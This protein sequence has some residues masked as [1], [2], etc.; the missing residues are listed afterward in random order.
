MEEQHQV[1]PESE[2]ALNASTAIEHMPQ[3]KDIV[4]EKE[5]ASGLLAKVYKGHQTLLQRTVAM[6]IL[7]KKDLGDDDSSLERFQQEASLAANLDHPNIAKVLGYG[8]ASSGDPYLTME[9][10]D[11]VTLREYLDSHSQQELSLKDFKAIFLPLLSALDYAHEKGIVHR[12]IK[13]G[14]IMLTKSVHD[15]LLPKLV[16]FGIAK[17]FIES[18]I[19]QHHTK[20]GTVIGTPAYMSPEQCLGK[21]VDGRSDLY[22]IACVMYEFLCSE[23]LFKAETPLALMGMHAQAQP[24][25]VKEFCRKSMQSSKLCST[26]LSTLQ[27]DP[28]ERPKTAA[29][30]SEKLSNDLG[31]LDSFNSKKQHSSVK[32]MLAAGL[33]ILLLASVVTALFNLNK[34]KAVTQVINEPTGRQL[35][36]LRIAKGDSRNVRKVLSQ[37]LSLIETLRKKED[38]STRELAEAYST[39]GELISLLLSQNKT[40]PKQRKDLEMQGLEL[41]Q[42]GVDIS[43]QGNMQ[44]FFFRNTRNEYELLKASKDGEKSIIKLIEEGNAR[45]PTSSE[46]IE[47][48]FDGILNSLTLNNTKQAKSFLKL[49]SNQHGEEAEHIRSIWLRAAEARIAIAENEKKKALAIIKPVLKELDS[50]IFMSQKSTIA[51]LQKAIGPILISANRAEQYTELLKKEVAL[52]GE[53]YSY[54]GIAQLYKMIAESYRVRNREEDAIDYTEKALHQYEINKGDSSIILDLCQ[55]LV[56]EISDMKDPKYSAKLAAYKAKVDSLTAMAGTK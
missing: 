32:N 5:L 1:K 26:I 10:V 46:N 44:K 41:A 18:N 25:S 34:S 2:D 7:S 21:P 45:W 4:L 51:L 40:S 50:G 35:S 55:R 6:K 39:A 28:A 17:V 23:A 52:R 37:Y 11:G 49:L 33:I 12:D 29:I 53:I 19:E 22:S 8:T 31:N 9:Y 43:L 15:E 27:K 13:P 48:I 3:I 14:N 30:L 56:Q 36:E 16:D 38:T 42:K 47:F 24:P 54:D 20:T